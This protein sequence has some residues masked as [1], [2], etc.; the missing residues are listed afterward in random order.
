MIYVLRERETG[1]YKFG[2]SR[3]E[4]RARRSR[5]PAIRRKRAALLQRRCTLEF[6]MWRDWPRDAEQMIHR[7]L[8]Q[9]WQGDEWFCDSQRLQLLLLF[10]N[11]LCGY[12]R[13]AK[14]FHAVKATLPAAW[15][16]KSRDKILCAHIRRFGDI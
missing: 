3:D 13:F 6:I 4:Y 9:S 2:S 7:Y 8:W 15:H 16:W 11:D 12:S 5:L 1:F 14:A 10:L